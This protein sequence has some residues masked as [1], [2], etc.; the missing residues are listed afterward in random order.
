MPFCLSS[1]PLAFISPEDTIGFLRQVSIL[2]DILDSDV[3][4]YL[5]SSRTTNP[6]ALRHV[7]PE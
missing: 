4:H 7:R 2:F 1:P 3:N 6:T 5:E